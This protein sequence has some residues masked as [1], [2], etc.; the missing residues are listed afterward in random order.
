MLDRQKI[1]LCFQT[2]GKFQNKFKAMYDF[3]LRLKPDRVIFVH[4]WFV[5]FGR[6]EFLAAFVNYGI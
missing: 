6:A 3:L 2:A 5:E 4:A 1:V